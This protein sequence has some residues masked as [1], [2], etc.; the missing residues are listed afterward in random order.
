MQILKDKIHMIIS[1]DTDKNLPKNS[2]CIHYNSLRELELEREK[3]LNIITVIY[4]KHIANIQH[5]LK[6]RKT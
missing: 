5:H 2:T 6:W 4:D 1:I 3:N